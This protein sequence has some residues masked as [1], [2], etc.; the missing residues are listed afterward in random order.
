MPKE[1]FL[2]GAEAVGDTILCAA[3]GPTDEQRARAAAMR[4]MDKERVSWGRHYD[5][6]RRGT[7]QAVLEADAGKV[8][9]IDPKIIPF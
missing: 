1:C 6:I 2:C 4:D 7:T 9:P 3:C 8:E 5:R